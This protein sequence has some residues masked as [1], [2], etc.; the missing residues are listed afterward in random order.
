VSRIPIACS[1]DV[2]DQVVRAEEWRQL[3]TKAITRELTDEGARLTFAPETVAA[4]EVAELVAREVNCCPFFTF[5][6]EITAQHL[7]L[8]VTAPEDSVAVVA[9]LVN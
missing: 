2:S 7:V 4:T 3:K 1:L 8:T 9:A 6:L 5:T